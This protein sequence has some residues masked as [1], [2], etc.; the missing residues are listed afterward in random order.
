[1][2]RP[3]GSLNK[4]TLAA[5]DAAEK[6]KFEDEG[7]RICGFLLR[8]AA[9]NS[10]S[11]ATRMQAAK[12]VLPYLKP[13]LSAVEQTVVEPAMTREEHE[14]SADL[15][16]ALRRAMIENPDLVQQILGEQ[17]KNATLSPVDNP[18]EQAPKPTSSDKTG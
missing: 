17:A 10:K 13:A 18:D 5:L 8:I 1:M 15:K 3:K 6:G 11:E 2:S 12:I 4:R 9:D 7:N 16:E 14:L